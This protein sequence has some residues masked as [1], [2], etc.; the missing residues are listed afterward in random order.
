MLNTII[1][2]NLKQFRRSR[3]WSLAK[4]AAMTKVSKAM[5]GQIERQ[6]SS[7]TIATL[8]K[9]A[10]GFHLPLSVLIEPCALRSD[11]LATA[12]HEQTICLDSD[13]QF[14][15]LFS[16]DPLL[17]CEMF[18]HQLQPDRTHLS[19]AHELGVIEDIIVISG[20]LEILVDESWQLLS[21]GD[22]LRF[23]ADKNH[24]YRN[25]GKKE[26]IFHN[27]IHY[28]KIVTCH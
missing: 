25:I 19:K 23:S 1:A 16:F 11:S 5:L 4:A 27:I 24:G 18:S 17:C 3:Q 9:I 20:E 13:L 12:S 14:R 7:P 6:E 8:W 15:V 21:A 2:K 10:K 22:T 26:V 28:P